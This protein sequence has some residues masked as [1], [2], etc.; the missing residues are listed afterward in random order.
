MNQCDHVLFS[1]RIFGDRMAMENDKFA[2]RLQR[3]MENQPYGKHHI[4]EGPTPLT[5]PNPVILATIHPLA[6][7]SAPVIL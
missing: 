3:A 1:L 2:L 4:R 7:Y 6:V 5:T